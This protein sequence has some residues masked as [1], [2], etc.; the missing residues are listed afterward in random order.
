MHNS[1]E[2]D[3]WTWGIIAAVVL[4]PSL[5]LWTTLLL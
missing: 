2:N 3:L 1:D 5:A 4:V